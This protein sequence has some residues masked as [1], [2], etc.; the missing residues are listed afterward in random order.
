MGSGRYPHV[1]PL[2]IRPQCKCP[3][4]ALALALGTQSLL[5]CP[6]H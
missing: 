4:F 6:I 2:P 5:L 1:D 3:G